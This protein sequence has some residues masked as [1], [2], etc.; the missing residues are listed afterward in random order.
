MML[1]VSGA[2]ADVRHTDVERVGILY[3][4]GNG[5]SAKASDGRRWAIDNAAYTGFDA[6]AYLRLISRFIGKP[7]CLFVACPDVVGDWQQTQELFQVWRPLIRHLGFPVGFVAQDGLTVDNTP[8]LDFNALFIGGTTKWKLSVDVDALL[9]EAARRGKWRHVGRVNSRRRIR[10]FWD[11]CDSL[12]GS[13]F[14]RWPKRIRQARRWLADFE[15]QPQL[16]EAQYES[17]V[18]EHH[19]DRS[20]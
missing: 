19:E 5:N 20:S 7:D 16:P 14:S 13:G 4:P 10:H 9:A 12:D 3:R 17:H 11:R 18:G 15:H 6:P 1:L 8:W 2:T